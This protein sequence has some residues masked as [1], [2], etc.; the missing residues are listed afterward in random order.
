MRHQCYIWLLRFYLKRMQI[1]SLFQQALLKITNHRLQDVHTKYD[2]SWVLISFYVSNSIIVC[3]DSVNPVTE[4]INLSSYHIYNIHDIFLSNWIFQVNCAIYN[5]VH[6]YTIKKK[7]RL[8]SLMTLTNSSI[9]NFSQYKHLS[10]NLSRLNNTVPWLLLILTRNSSRTK[11]N[12]DA[13]KT[14]MFLFCE[15]LVPPPSP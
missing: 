13:K 15:Y 9:V 7:I 1:S 4:A 10:F 11:I 12:L 5:C 2:H 14:T 3:N 8:F 6:L